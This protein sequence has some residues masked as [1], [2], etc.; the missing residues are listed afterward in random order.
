MAKLKEILGKTSKGEV[1]R[2]GFLEDATYPTGEKVAQVAFWN[3]YGTQTS[4]PRPFFRNF[5]ADHKGEWGN[6]LG[7]LMRI[8]NNDVYECL[9]VM[10]IRMKGQLEQQIVDTDAPALSPVTIMLRKI[11]SEKGKN[12]RVRFGVDA[13]ATAAMY[14]EAVSRVKEGESVAGVNAKPL[15][16]TNTMRSNVDFDIQ[17][18]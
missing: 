8:R 12:K 7:K 6:D 4:P 17:E 11:R 1:L 9:H 5:I 13:P 14:W 18:T 16:F 15:I 2:L 10:G 3:E